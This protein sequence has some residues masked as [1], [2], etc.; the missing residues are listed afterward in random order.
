MKAHKYCKTSLYLTI[1]TPQYFAYFIY[2][3]GHLLTSNS[4]N[5]NTLSVHFII[6]KNSNLIMAILMRGNWDIS[7]AQ[8]EAGRDQ[9][10]IVSGAFSG[11]GVHPGV[12]GASVVQVRGTAWSLIIQNLADGVWQNSV[13]KLQFPSSNCSYFRIASDDGGGGGDLDFNDLV[14]QCTAVATSGATDYFV[15]GNVSVYEGLCLFNPCWRDWLVID[16][17]Y[18]LIEALKYPILRDYITKYYPNAP[19]ELA[20][21]PPIPMP[22]PPPFRPL[23]LPL[24]GDTLLPT[25]QATL[26]KSVKFEDN[27]LGKKSRGVDEELLSDTYVPVKSISLANTVARFDVNKIAIA[28]LAEK[29]RFRCNTDAY[30]S[31]ILRFIEY[32][33][34][35]AEMAG[36]AYTGTGARQNMGQVITDSFGNYLFRFSR[37]DFQD[38]QELSLDVAAGES[39]FAQ[40]KPDL[41]V[42]ILNPLNTSQVLYETALNAN[43]STCKRLNI[44]IPKGSIGVSS[45]PCVGQSLIQYVGNTLVA[46]DSAGNRGGS[47]TALHTSGR[48]SN[49]GLH[50][51][52]WSGTLRLVGC[53]MADPNMPY[54][55]MRYRRVGEATWQNVEEGCWL[56]RMVG[57]SI[58]DYSIRTTQ[59]LRIDGGGPVTTNCYMNVN[60]GFP[61]FGTG[62]ITSIN[63]KALLTT[64]FY[65]NISRRGA[66][67][68]RLEGY[69]SA[70]NKLSGVDESIVLYLD[71]HGVESVIDP[72]VSL[73]GSPLGNCA[74]FTLPKDAAGNPIEN[75]PMT[76]RLKAVQESGFMNQ[77]SLTIGKGAVGNIDLI[78]VGGWSAL[79]N[80]TDFPNA[81]NKTSLGRAYNFAS[82]AHSAFC[83]TFTGTPDEPTVGDFIDVIVQPDIS[84]IT[85]NGN[86]LEPNQNFCAFRLRV[87]G[88]IRHTDGTSGYPNFSSNEVLIGIER[89]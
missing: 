37:T 23:V 75:A 34:T 10:F 38:V 65:T 86:W 72:N 73:G 6:T 85:P 2:F 19:L 58:S 21:K 8:K 26:F 81:A 25:K 62:W 5:P 82:T 27:T 69:D 3:F 24:Q 77:Y 15:Y 89:V 79:P 67:E 71:N 40:V 17:R 1:E 47:G 51:A 48:V 4:F 42:Q 88:S 20:I 36:G 52:A 11:N 18:K 87:D 83:P 22:D 49:N 43:I 54:Y 16:S 63:V 56:P 46:R 61:A 31:G 64:S 57:G 53:L 76:V 66:V 80:T 33:R 59:S 35:A 74:L 70:G 41:I 60:S 14:V 28:G 13:D 7:V 29:F 44:C 68:F 30:G 55:T 9:R 84:P 50:C 78:K 32:D 12:V 39:F 45:N